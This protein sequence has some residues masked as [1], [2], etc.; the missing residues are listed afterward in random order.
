MDG[1][2]FLFHTSAANFLGSTHG[3]WFYMYGVRKAIKWRHW[4]LRKIRSDQIMQRYVTLENNVMQYASCLW[5]LEKNI[6]QYYVSALR[7]NNALFVFLAHA[8][9]HKNDAS[10]VLKFERKSVWDSIYSRAFLSSHS[11]I[12]DYYFYSQLWTR[13]E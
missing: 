9:H 12:V 8:S 4:L 2:S 5:N 7:L 1:S 3:C 10:M 11:S 13:G 6:K